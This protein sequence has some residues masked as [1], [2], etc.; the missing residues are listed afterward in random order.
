MN[1]I[2]VRSLSQ[3]KRLAHN[4][5]LEIYILLNGG[6]KSSKCI[7]YDT[8]AIN[9]NS[10]GFYLFNYIDDTDGFYTEAEL[11]SKTNIYKAIKRGALIAEV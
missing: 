9:T 8:K 10:K 7:Y 2:F 6:G 11:K 4:K 3:L 1:H 5:H